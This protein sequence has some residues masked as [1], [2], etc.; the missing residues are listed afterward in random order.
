VLAA[1]TRGAPLAPTTLVA[2]LASVVPYV[3]GCG[4]LRRLSLQYHHFKS[5]WTCDIFGTRGMVSYLMG[6]LEYL[7]LYGRLKES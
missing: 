4:I 7:N 6:F 1:P 5:T 2:S 3:L